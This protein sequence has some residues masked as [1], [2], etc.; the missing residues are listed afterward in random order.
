[1]SVYL[2]ASVLVPLFIDDIFTARSRAFLQS[3]PEILVSDFARAEFAS[4]VG[5]AVRTGD[6]A[7]A[8]ALAVFR[9]FDTWAETSPAAETT[10]QDVRTTEAWLRRLDLNLRAPDALNIAI[11]KRL[12]AS[13][14][15]FDH[16]MAEAALAL[17]VEVALA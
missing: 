10:A 2:D 3:G 16:R 12:G 4:V 8:Q 9:D 15:T 17:G 11:A 6:I 1:M 13:L 14:A 7:D 5:R